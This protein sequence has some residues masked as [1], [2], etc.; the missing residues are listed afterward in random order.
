MHLAHDLGLGQAEHIAVV[1]QGLGM[2]AKALAAKVFVAEA[3]VLQHHPH[4][5]VEDHD[6]LLEKP[7]ETLAN[8]NCTRHR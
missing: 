7:I 4:R 8:R 2:V 3:L 5:S 6:P 1:A